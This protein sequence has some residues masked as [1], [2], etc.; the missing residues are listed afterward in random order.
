[1]EKKIKILFISDAGD[2]RGAQKSLMELILT[3]KKFYN[4]EPILITKKK[5]N[6]N[7]T[8][9]EYGI[10]NYSFWYR[11]VMASSPYN[12][13][14]IN[15]IK[16]IFGYIAYGLGALRKYKVNHLGIDFAGIDIIHTN[17]NRVDLGL[18]L[19]DK[20][21]IPHIMHLREFGAEDFGSVIYR[22]HMFKDF[23]KYTDY[24]IAISRCVKKGWIQKGLCAKQI[25]VIYNGLDTTR[26]QRLKNHHNRKMQIVVAGAINKFKGQIQVVQACGL[27]PDYIRENIQVTFL[28]NGKF[29]YLDQLKKEIQKNHLEKQFVFGGYCNDLEQRLNKFDVGIMPSKAEGFGRVT[30][31]YMLSGLCVI[32]SDTGANPEIIIDKES[33][34]I[35]PYGDIKTLAAKIKL[36]YENAEIRARLAENGYK[37][38][39]TNYTTEINASNI[40]NLYKEILGM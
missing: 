23:N 5:N 11:Y 14:F 36:I 20:Y 7:R 19:K 22:R 1:M 13:K 2:K 21:K 8:C 3:L 4:V 18:Y 24:F 15:F 38:A 37:R 39:I 29:D 35:Y 17:T 6:L 9:D 28:G 34:C 12:K 26:Y 30:V 25:Q 33:G 27:L 16:H 31:E 40:Y 32:A 10:E